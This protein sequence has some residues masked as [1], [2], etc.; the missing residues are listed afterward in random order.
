MFPQSLAVILGVSAYDKVPE[1]IIIR[2]S[3]LLW[4]MYSFALNLVYQTF[5]TTFLIDPGLEHEISTVDELLE[6]GM[7]LGIPTTVDTVLPDLT[8]SRYFRHTLCTDMSLCFHRL[9]YEGNFA[10]LCS[11]YNTEY[12]EAHKYVDSNGKSRL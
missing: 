6:S 3:F 9:A 7:E 12:D 1:K 2:A 11:R 5:L 10:V 8:S 4:V